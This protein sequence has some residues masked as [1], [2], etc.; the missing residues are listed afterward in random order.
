MHPEEIS[1]RIHGVKGLNTSL[2]SQIMRQLIAS[3]TEPCKLLREIGLNDR[4][5]AQFKQANARY[6]AS[7]L[8]WLEQV[9]CQILLYGEVGYPERFKHINDAPLLLVQGNPQLLQQP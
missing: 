7:T 9:C 3:G 6:L 4:Q 8:R 2:A 1:L 5:Q